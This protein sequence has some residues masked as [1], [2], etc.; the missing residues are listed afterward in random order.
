MGTHAI[1]QGNGTQTQAEETTNQQ[2]LTHVNESQQDFEQGWAHWLLS[3]S[4]KLERVYVGRL[5]QTFLLTRA[6]QRRAPVEVSK[7]GRSTKEPRCRAETRRSERPRHLFRRDETAW[8][9]SNRWRPARGATRIDKQMQDKNR[10]AS[11][12]TLHRLPVTA[13]LRQ[14]RTGSSLQVPR[15]SWYAYLSNPPTR[16][17]TQC[18]VAQMNA[19]AP[20]HSFLDMRC[21][22]PFETSKEH[23]EPQQRARPSVDASSLHSTTVYQWLQQPLS[24]SLRP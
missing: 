1:T 17:L 24:K 18:T 7:F 19:L 22:R 16:F 6:D 20:S 13:K 11:A 8:D 2:K 23:I 21:Q 15:Q 4:S 12:L 14:Q 5:P 3:V 9:R 10:N